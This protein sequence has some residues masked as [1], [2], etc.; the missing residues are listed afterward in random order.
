MFVD[1]SAQEFY[2]LFTGILDKKLF[3][4]I[5][6]RDGTLKYGFESKELNDTD[7]KTLALGIMEAWYDFFDPATFTFDDDFVLGYDY[8]YLIRRVG[9]KAIFDEN[10]VVQCQSFDGL[11][12]MSPIV[13]M[14][15]FLPFERPL[16]D[17]TPH[18]HPADREEYVWIPGSVWHYPSRDTWH[19]YAE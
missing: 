11:P 15:T 14:E 4:Q 7:D 6:N 9:E 3:F 13:F 5:V 2:Q 18:I 17:N 10:R 1:K 8:P 19:G 16:P 12:G